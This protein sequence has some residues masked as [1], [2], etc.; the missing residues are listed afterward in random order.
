[1]LSH[2][3]FNPLR[4]TVFSILFFS[5]QTFA[6]PV[7]VDLS[8]WMVDGAGNWSLSQTIEPNDT[9]LQSLNSIPTVLF[10]GINSQGTALSGTIKGL[11]AGG[12]DDF[13]GFVL[14][15]DDNDLF[16]TNLTTDYILVDWKQGTQSGWDEGL[17][18]SRVTGGPIASSGVD[19]SGD[20]WTHTGNV[21]LLDRAATLGSTGWLDDMDYLFEIIF[22]P[23]NIQVSVNGVQQFNING[24]F[25]NGSFGFYNFS[26]PNV[27]YSGITEQDAPPVCGSAGQPPCNTA[28]PEPA[29]FALIGLGL[30]G[31][32]WSRRRKS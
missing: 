25:K 9:A 16:G 20:A 7:P 27:L 29:M 28:V 10:N 22:N 14:G 31:I 1:M 15:Y 6:I 30:A 23:T 5:A 4:S 19:V 11:A 26:Q 13:I 24:T 32:G 21:T 8:S 17:A 12:D 2:I 3:K 18:I